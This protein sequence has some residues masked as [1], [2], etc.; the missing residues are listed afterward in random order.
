MPRHRT[1]VRLF[2]ASSL[3]ALLVSSSSAYA[4]TTL[5]GGTLETQVWTTAG[6]P[7]VVLSDITVPKNAALTI[8]PGVEVIFANVDVMSKTGLDPN[9]VELTIE[10]RLNAF[11]TAEKP[12]R[13]RAGITQ[14]GTWFGIVLKDLNDFGL[15]PSLGNVIISDAEHGFHVS[16]LAGLLEGFTAT[17]NTVGVYTD[18]PLSLRNAVIQDSSEAGVAARAPTGA[19]NM[20][21]NIINTTLHKAQ[22]GVSLIADTDASLYVQVAASIVAQTS[23]GIGVQPNNTGTAMG[24]VASSDLWQNGADVMGPI[25]MNNTFSGNPLYVSDKNLRITS[26]SPCRKYNNGGHVGGLPYAGD[27]TKNLV[28]V[29]WDELTLPIQGSPYTVTGD[30]TIPTSSKLTLEPGV[31]LQFNPIDEMKAGDDPTKAELTVFSGALVVKG[32][33]AQPVRIRGVMQSPGSWMG[34]RFRDWSSENRMWGLIVSDAM[35]GFR[36]ST[37]SNADITRF[38]AVGNEY[39]VYVDQGRPLIADAVIRNNTKAGVY[40]SSMSG[41]SSDVTIWQST[42]HS[43]GTYGVFAEN[44]TSSSTLYVESSIVTQNSYGIRVDDP[45]VSGAVSYTNVFGNPAGNYVGVTPDANSISA[46]PMYEAAPTNLKL[47]AGSPCIDKLAANNVSGTDNV[48]TPRPV[49]GDGANGATG[50]MGAIEYVPNAVCGDDALG[51]GEMCDDGT[52]NGKYGQCNATCSGPAGYC[53]DGKM[54]EG[55]GC[56][57]GNLSNGD[58]CPANCMPAMCGDGYLQMGTEECDD[59]NQ[60]DEDGCSNACKPARCGDGITQTA[61]FE[62][63]D[64]GNTDDTDS[65]LTACRTAKCGDGIVHKVLEF[66]DDGNQV[67]GDG[68]DATCI[69]EGPIAGASSS[70]SSVS[71]SGSGGN[72]AGNGGA[73]GAGGV[74]GNGSG[75]GTNDADCDCRAAPGFVEK[76]A[77]SHLGW[78]F[79]A[80][81][82]A[83]LRRFKNR[84]KHGR[85]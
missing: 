50:D 33:T 3:F 83:S 23:V 34:I 31:T 85:S 40:F 2:A 73:G 68:C 57:D 71:S 17:G 7:Y 54:E 39:G 26:N 80:G 19:S 10:G 38:T 13:F 66:C 41:S 28:G 24:N 59:G 53:G 77:A 30:L 67:S 16:G 46:D 52:D 18:Q 63:C 8:M 81:I 75:G 47:K 61:F 55:E 51:P 36:M 4:D 78:V 9:K 65:C 48:E 45:D 49:D 25:T 69:P 6:S 62:Q 76:H 43:N 27:K 64:D 70:A 5:M 21:V 72:G 82:L 14:P 58:A 12:I 1:F 60:T 37:Q 44:V 84:S 22:T 74:G 79:V 42:I 32:T 29:L 11:G 20:S 35:A 56:D 15:T